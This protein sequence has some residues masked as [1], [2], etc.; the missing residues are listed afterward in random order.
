MYAKGMSNRDIKEHIFDI[1][2]HELSPET[3]SVITDKILPQAKEWQNRALEEIYAIVFM[4]CMVLK[5][6]VDGAVRNVT[7]YFVIGISLEGQKSCL[8][9]YLA[10]TE[11]AKYWLTGYSV[12]IGH[13]IRKL[14][15]SFL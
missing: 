10:E 7:I 11:S 6:R 15:D 2:G 13:R 1:Y 5:M 3:V 12:Q 8:G 4:D 9:L 14:V